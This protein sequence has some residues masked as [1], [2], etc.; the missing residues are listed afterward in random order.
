[1][2]LTEFGTLAVLV[3]VALVAFTV[4]VLRLVMGS[5]QQ[6]AQ[7][8]LGLV[9]IVLGLLVV[10][11]V[12]FTFYRVQSTINSGGPGPGMDQFPTPTNSG[13]FSGGGSLP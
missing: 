5:P 1:M 3:L 12:G 2:D 9:V 8:C 4:S 10:G 6:R 7:G 11:S 13:G